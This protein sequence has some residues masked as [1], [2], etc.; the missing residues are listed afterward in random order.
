MYT[1]YT[2]FEELTDDFLNREGIAVRYAGEDDE[3]VEVSY[4]E[5]AAMIFS[6]TDELRA[7]CADVE[8]IRAAQT[9]DTVVDIFAHVIAGCDVVMA[10]PMVPQDAVD[11]TMIAAIGARSVR[12]STRDARGRIIVS[13]KEGELLFFTSGTTSR[14][15]IVRLTSESFCTSAWSGQSM[16]ACGEGDVILSVLPLAH[17]F[18][19]VCSLLWGLAYGATVALGRGIGRIGEDAWLFRPTI[20]PAVPSIIGGMLKADA[21]NPELKIVLIGAAPCR[22]ETVAALREKGIATYLGYGLTETASGI[23]ITQDLDEPEALYPCPGAD[24]IIEKDGE[25]AVATPCMMQ[26]YIGAIPMFDGDRFYTGDIGSID[27]KGRL[28]LVGRKKDVLLLESGT[29]VFCPE[30]EEDLTEMTGVTDLGLILKRGHIELIAGPGTDEEALRKAV[31]EYNQQLPGSLQI[32]DVIIS[33][34]PLPRTRT[35]KLKRYELQE[36]YSR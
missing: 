1:R 6:R 17:V 29:K 20:L 10:D 7:E 24:F 23:A 19:F 33:V 15:K 27:E 26:G 30:Y 35:G 12:L 14:S 11:R 25:V 2:S 32:H 3:I 8:V 13:R 28:H 18:G 31:A 22:P 4:P 34:A 36:K 5:L 16:L 21:F 9:I